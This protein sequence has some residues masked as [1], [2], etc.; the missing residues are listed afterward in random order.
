MA[1]VVEGRRLLLQR[2]KILSGTGDFGRG[3]SESDLG[4]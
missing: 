3:Q 2:V 1:E 4:R